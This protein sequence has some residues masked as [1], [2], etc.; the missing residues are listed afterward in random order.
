MSGDQ[1]TSLVC[2]MLYQLSY[3]ALGSKLLGRKDIQ[4]LI[5]GA[6]TSESNFLLWNTPDRCCHCGSRL[7]TLAVRPNSSII[8]S[9]NIALNCMQV[10]RFSFLEKKISNFRT[11]VH[12]DIYN[13]QIVIVYYAIISCWL[14]STSHPVVSF[15]LS[16]FSDSVYIHLKYIHVCLRCLQKCTS[17]HTQTQYIVYTYIDNPGYKA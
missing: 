8:H 9:H 6:H 4:V 7:D 5:L 15:G 3:Q 12:G 10:P 17:K 1:T 2:M 16:I 11:W 14:R 13:I